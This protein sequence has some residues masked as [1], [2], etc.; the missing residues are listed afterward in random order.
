M[1]WIAETH[2]DAAEGPLK[3]AYARIVRALGRV[4]PFYR[5]YSVSPAH[6]DAHLDFY[7]RLGRIGALSKKRKELIAVAVSAENG[8]RHCTALHAGLLRA[9]KVDERV[10]AALAADPG[11]ALDAETVTGDDAVM[12]RDA[13]GEVHHAERGLV[14]EHGTGEHG[15][16]VYSGS[17][18]RP[19]PTR[20]V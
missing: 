19:S 18:P 3:A 8:C 6:L 13:T 7:E 15:P 5:A 1:A 10:V 16:A 11:A 14:P 9:H 20:L 4:I 2:E 17:T 12:L